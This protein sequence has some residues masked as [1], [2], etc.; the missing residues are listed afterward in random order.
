MILTVQST[1]NGKFRLGINYEDS[2]TIFQNERGTSVEL[3]IGN[4]ELSLKTTCGP[5]LKKGFDLYSL[6][7]HY[8]IIQNNFHIYHRGNPTKL[9]FVHDRSNGKHRL[10]FISKAS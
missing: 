8:W 4:I 3:L 5:P 6:E 1:G 10:T 2:Q 9:E 7:L